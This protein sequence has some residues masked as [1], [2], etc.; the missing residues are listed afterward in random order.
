VAG[1]EASPAHQRVTNAIWCSVLSLKPQLDHVISPSALA[2]TESP[3]FCCFPCAQIY[4]QAGYQGF[5]DA[6]SARGPDFAAALTGLSY[7][8]VRRMAPLFPYS[9]PCHCVCS[10]AVKALCCAWCRWRH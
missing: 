6:H 1:G 8:L 7:Q 5:R 3:D 9:R 10:A 4:D 2:S